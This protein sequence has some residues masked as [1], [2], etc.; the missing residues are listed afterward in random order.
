MSIGEIYGIARDERGILWIAGHSGLYRMNFDQAWNPT[1]RRLLTRPAR[2]LLIRRN[3]D[4]I[5]GTSGGGNDKF[6][7][8]CHV[9]ETGCDTI[10]SYHTAGKLMK[11]Q[12]LFEDTHNALWVGTEYGAY[13]VYDNKVTHIGAQNGLQ[14]EN[15]YCITQDREGTMWFGTGGGVVK[16]PEPWILSYDMKEG[17]SGYATLS[18]LEDTRGDLWVGMYNGLNK[19]ANDESVKFW[20]ETDGLVHHTVR[21]VAM[22]GRGRVWLSTPLGLNLY[23]RGVIQPCPV[24]ELKGPIDVWGICNDRRGGLWIGLRG[25]LINMTEAGI[26]QSLDSSSGLTHD[27]AE[28][29]CV[30][31]RGR[32]WFT[33][34]RRGAGVYTDGVVRF[35]TEADGLTSDWV[36]SVLEDSHGMIWIGTESGVARWSDSER[37]ALPLSDFATLPVHVLLEDS[38]GNIWLGTD[39]GAFEY[40]DSSFQRYSAD[41]G[42]SNDVIQAGIVSRNGTVWFG[43]NGGVSRLEPTGQ[44]LG[45]PVPAVYL[46]NVLAGDMSKIVA[47]GG[48]V[49]YD[50][51]SVVFIFNAL[52]YLHEREILFQWMLQGNDP[53]WLIPERCDTPTSPRGTMSSQ[54]ERQTETPSGHSQPSSHSS[55]IVRIGRHGGLSPPVLQS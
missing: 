7:V 42:L 41:D 43:T 26:A 45:V 12:A 50:D 17:L 37:R 39:H 52:S 47:V 4:L 21:S 23:Q 30:D 16:L 38:S 8:V 3:G 20:D 51:R 48:A 10:V 31:R 34:G 13:R 24:V 36:H 14:N 5:V 6:G 46:K 15:V 49:D 1:S 11:A 55:S 40:T 33:N 25:K 9:R 32:L 27:V 2:S 54:F 22:D 53:D 44:P 28:P 35:V 18:L 29:L 19:I